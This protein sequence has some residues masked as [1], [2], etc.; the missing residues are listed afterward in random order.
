MD[1][2]KVPHITRGTKLEREVDRQFQ[3]MRNLMCKRITVVSVSEEGVAYT[4]EGK[5]WSH[6]PDRKVRKFV[7]AST[8]L[9]MYAFRLPN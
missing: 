4:E 1:Q 6:G 3:I 2:L 9:N 7:T 8:F 5:S